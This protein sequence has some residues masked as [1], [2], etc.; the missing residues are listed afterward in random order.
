MYKEILETYLAYDRLQGCDDAPAVRSYIV[1]SCVCEVT[2][3]QC[4]CILVVGFVSPLEARAVTASI[5]LD[6][7]I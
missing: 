4:H 5:Q 2:E 1:Y 7:R 3:G 6:V